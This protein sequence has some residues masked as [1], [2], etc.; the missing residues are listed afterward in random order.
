MMGRKKGTCGALS[1]SIQMVF[2]LLFF[3][4]A[5]LKKIYKRFVLIAPY[6]REISLEL[7]IAIQTSSAFGEF[8]QLRRHQSEIYQGTIMG[9]A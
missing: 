4:M 7:Y 3:I 8:M 5:H 6:E 1:R 2:F 9:T